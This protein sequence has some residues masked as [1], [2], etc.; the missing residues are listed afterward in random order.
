MPER[1]SVLDPTG[2]APE[3]KGQGMAQR[4]DSLAGKT[5]YLIDCRFDDGDIFL[6]E[7]Q[8][9]LGVHQEHRFYLVSRYRVVV[10]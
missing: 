3:I 1:I 8:G 9:W 6:Q 4:W 7:M 10:H 5:I 2:F